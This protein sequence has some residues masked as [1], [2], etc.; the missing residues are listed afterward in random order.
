MT[1]NNLANLDYDQNRMEAARKE[2]E[3]ALKIDVSWPRKTP[4]P[5]CPT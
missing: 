3:E 2:D 5:T 1:L 4:I